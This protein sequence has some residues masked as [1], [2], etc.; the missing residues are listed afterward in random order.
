MTT[1]H[2]LTVANVEP[3]TRDSVTIT[4]A[5][6][7]ALRSVYAFCPGQHLTLKTRPAGKS[8]AAATPSA[9]A[10]RRQKSA[11]RSKPSTAAVS[12]AMPRAI[13]SRVWNLR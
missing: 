13:F 1:F 6:P 7:D 10:V 9:A 11:W 2:S 8:Y 12:P 4:F 5:I 3:E